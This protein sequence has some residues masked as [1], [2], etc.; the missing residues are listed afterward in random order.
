[1]NFESVIGIEIHVE[2]STENKMFSTAKKLKNSKLMSQ[3]SKET[4]YLMAS[5]IYFKL[6]MKEIQ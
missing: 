2:L 3:L 6:S 4:A 1:M 5:L